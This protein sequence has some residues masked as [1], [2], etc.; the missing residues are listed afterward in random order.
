MGLKSSPPRVGTRAR[1]GCSSGVVMVRT[2]PA[3]A[4]NRNP[5]NQLRIQSASS[6]QMRAVSSQSAKT[7]IRGIT[8]SPMN[9]DNG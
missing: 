4:L 5:G 1:K 3:M 2:R 6:S 9:N 8:S 7:I